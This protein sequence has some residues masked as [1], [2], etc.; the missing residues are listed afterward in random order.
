MGLHVDENHSLAKKPNQ[1]DYHNRIV[2][3][4]DHYLADAPAKELKR[5]KKGPTTPVVATN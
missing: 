1:I 3:W 5:L 4:F 2:D